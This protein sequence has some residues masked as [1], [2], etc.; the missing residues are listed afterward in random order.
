[1]DALLTIFSYCIAIV[2]GMIGVLLLSLGL[3]GLY[4]LMEKLVK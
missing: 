1:M 4:R 3:Y 2:V